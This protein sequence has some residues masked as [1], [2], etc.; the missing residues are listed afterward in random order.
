MIIVGVKMDDSEYTFFGNF[1]HCSWFKF[2][3]RLKSVEGYIVCELIP[4][5]LSGSE[6]R[7][8]DEGFS[9]IKSQLNG[10]RIQTDCNDCN[11]Y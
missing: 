6:N 3:D 4:S 5:V 2:W 7:G 10:P 9:L 11:C 1:N 8:R